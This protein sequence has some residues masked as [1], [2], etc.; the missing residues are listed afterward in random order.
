MHTNNNI[1]QSRILGWLTSLI[2]HLG[3]GLLFLG[4]AIDIP[5]DESVFTEVAFSSYTAADNQNITQSTSR[6]AVPPAQA[7]RDVTP[8]TRVVDLPKR[9][10]QENEPP[11]LPVETK[12]RVKIQEDIQKMGLKVDPLSG[13][14]KESRIKPGT[15]PPGE[16]DIK[17]A[18]RIDVGQKISATPPA[19]GVGKNVISNKPYEI[20]WDSGEREI[21]ADPLPSFPEGINREVVLKIRI[22]VLPDGTMGET[23]PLQKG[24]ATLEALTLQALKNWRFNAL[25]PSAPQVNQSGIIAFRFVLK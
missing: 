4:V 13:A 15:L 22:T 9:R 8:R 25:E 5:V 11:T 2:L 7:G 10:M 12:D 21:L 24:E 17:G 18:R 3:M 23:L 14:A 6:T 1:R 19:E 20:N 16:R